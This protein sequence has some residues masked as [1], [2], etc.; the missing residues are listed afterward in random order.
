MY[1]DNS[2]LR[3]EDFAFPFGVSTLLAFR[4][5]FGEE[6]LAAILEE[7]V[8]KAEEK[9]KDD[10]DDSDDPPNSGTLALDA[11]CCT[12][13]QDIDLL[14]QAREK[15]EKTVGE[16]CE[17]IGQ[18]KP[19]MYRKRAR[20]DYLRLSKSKNDSFSGT[21]TAAIHPPGQEVHR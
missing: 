1:K 7:S 8:P 11:T 19:R 6:C 3:I 20:K 16:L 2:Q 9:E 18:K 15:A 21:Q 17:L 10:S 12:Y 13:P 5:R 14:N 4:K